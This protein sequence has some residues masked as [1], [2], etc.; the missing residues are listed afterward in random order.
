MYREDSALAKTFLEDFV[1]RQTRR[2]IHQVQESGQLDILR[3]PRPDAMRHP[4]SCPVMLRVAEEYF[5][6]LH[7]AGQAELTVGDGAQ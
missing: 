2:N 3:E 4:L 6:C 7:L 5:D 1:G